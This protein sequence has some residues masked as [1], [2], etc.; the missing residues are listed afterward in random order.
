[1]KGHANYSLRAPRTMNDAFGPYT[2]R[3]FQE[4][5]SLPL[6]WWAIVIVMFLIFLVTLSAMK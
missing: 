2:S 4:H 6:W 1:M 5:P 3:D